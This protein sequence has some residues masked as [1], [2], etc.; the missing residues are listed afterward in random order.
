MDKATEKKLKQIELN[1]ARN[2]TGAG[3]ERIVLT[4]SEWDAIQAGAV[5]NHT[6]EK[7]LNHSDTESIKKLALP[8]EQR[9]LSSTQMRTAQTM[10]DSGYT[11]IEVADRLGVGL[12]TLKVALDD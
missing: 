9:A 4:Q 8:K 7:I 6:L 12:T 3:K 1:N 5:S 11:Q 10:L 2:S